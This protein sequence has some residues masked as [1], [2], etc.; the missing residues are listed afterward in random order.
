MYPSKM[1]FSKIPHISTL[2]PIKV[3][4]YYPFFFFVCI[5][6]LTDLEFLDVSNTSLYPE[7]LGKFLFKKKLNK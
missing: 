2:M 7:N 4:F 5:S 1:I 3:V 6:P